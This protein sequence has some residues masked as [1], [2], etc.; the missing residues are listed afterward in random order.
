MKK[1]SKLLPSLILVYLGF[2]LYLVPYSFD[3]YISKDIL[4]SIGTICISIGFFLVIIDRYS[5]KILNMITYNKS[6]SENGI[7]ELGVLSEVSFPNGVKIHGKEIRIVLNSKFINK[8]IDSFLIS[9]LQNTDLK[10]DVIIASCDDILE[11]DRLL[12]KTHFNPILLFQN[13]NPNINIRYSNEI[14]SNHILLTIDYVAVYFSTNI[15]NGHVN[16]CVLNSMNADFEKYKLLFR[17]VWE[18][19]KDIIRKEA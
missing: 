4:M 14:I 5:T 1:F 9:L 8:Y 10:I 6:K 11:P 16:Y 12:Q 19:S 17:R 7:V 13:D 15:D 2:I 3:T 18:D